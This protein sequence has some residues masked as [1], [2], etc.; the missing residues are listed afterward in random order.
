METTRLKK[1]IDNSE[2]IGTSFHGVTITLRLID[3][4]KIL[5]E[6]DSSMNDG[7]DK[8]NFEWVRKNMYGWVFTVYSWKEYRPLN[9]Y[10]IIEWHIGG[11]DKISTEV[12]FSEI[13]DEYKK[14]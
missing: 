11:K 3:L 6:P 12:A 8:V 4:K 1:K 14:L 9:E 5:G 2:A 10:E 7:S 13:I